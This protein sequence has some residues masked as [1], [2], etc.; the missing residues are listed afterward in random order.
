MASKGS[1]E[2]QAA[3]DKVNSL[4]SKPEDAQLLQVPLSL[5]PSASFGP[6]SEQYLE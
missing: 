4:K 1:P 2:F 5:L 3:A 6:S